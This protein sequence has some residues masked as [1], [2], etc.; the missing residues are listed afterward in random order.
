MHPEARTVTVSV[1]ASPNKGIDI[2]EIALVYQTLCLDDSD[3]SQVI[4]KDDDLNE[5]VQGSRTFTIT[6]HY[7]TDTK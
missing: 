2:M 7:V 3:I 5:L 1:G 4:S 6:N